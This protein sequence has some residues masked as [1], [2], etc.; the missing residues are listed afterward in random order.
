[1]GSYRVLVD[2]TQ[3][4]Q[5]GYRKNPHS[6]SWEVIKKEIYIGQVYDVTNSSE[7][8]YYYHIFYIC[9]IKN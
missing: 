7:S 8:P 5:P 6:K 1:M 3:G 2:I 9:S 4:S